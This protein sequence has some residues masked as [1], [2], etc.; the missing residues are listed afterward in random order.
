M[1]K[2]IVTTWGRQYDLIWR[3]L[4]ALQ[5]EADKK[6]MFGTGVIK[7]VILEVP[8]QEL[9]SFL[10]GEGYRGHLTDDGWVLVSTMF[11]EVCL[12]G[13]FQWTAIAGEIIRKVICHFASSARLEFWQRGLEDGGLFG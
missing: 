6:T 2:I 10:R 9:V 8:D 13:R 11:E 3:E 12:G 7:E 1:A 5:C 4:F